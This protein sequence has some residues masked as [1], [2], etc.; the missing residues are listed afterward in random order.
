LSIGLLLAVVV[1]VWPVPTESA[2]ATAQFQVTANIQINCAITAAPLA[3]GTYQPGAANLTTPLDAQSQITVTCTKTGQWALAL[4]AGLFPGATTTTRQMT[5]PGG[6]GLQYSLFS[7]AARTVNWGNTT[8]DD[9]NGTGQGAPEVIP[10]YGRIPPGQTS[11]V[12][13][14]YADTITATISF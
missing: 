10:V 13:G 14:G 12:P 8:S 7:D 5:G 9:V 2:T 6:V 4:D 11:A 3:F 1:D